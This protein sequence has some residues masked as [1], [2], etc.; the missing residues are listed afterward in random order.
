MLFIEIIITSKAITLLTK[1]ITTLSMQIYS[2]CPSSML[3]SQRIPQ[4][5]SLRS[6]ICSIFCFIRYSIVLHVPS[7]PPIPS[8]FIHNSPQSP[9][10]SFHSS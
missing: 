9:H 8:P 5:S 2:I 6:S 3:I 7:V 4:I 1:Q 10:L